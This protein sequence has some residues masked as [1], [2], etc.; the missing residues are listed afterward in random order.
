LQRANQLTG[1]PFNGQNTTII[2]DTPADIA[3]ARTFGARVVAVSSGSYSSATLTQFEPDF[4]FENFL[5]KERV[6]EALIP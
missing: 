5:D 3:C 2:G 4:L 1:Q 6:L